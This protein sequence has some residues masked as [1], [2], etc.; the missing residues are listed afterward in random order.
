MYFR[1]NGLRKKC[2]DKFLK[3]PVSY[4]IL[5]RNMVNWL[6]HS[7]ILDYSTFTIFTD[8]CGRN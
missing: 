4:Q 6:Q 1:N 5:T 3:T 8:H 2:F 7:C